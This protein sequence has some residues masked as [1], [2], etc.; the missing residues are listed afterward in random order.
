MKGDVYVDPERQHRID[1][2][3]EKTGIKNDA[4]FKP[5]SGYKDM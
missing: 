5:A 2:L 1:E 4:I 3:K